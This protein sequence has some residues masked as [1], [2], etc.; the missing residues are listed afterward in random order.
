M[1]CLI[2]FQLWFLADR[3]NGQGRR[4]GGQGGKLPRAPRQRRGPA[5]LQNEFLSSL[6]TKAK[7]I[8]QIFIFINLRQRFVDGR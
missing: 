7:V 1:R 6:V 2:G 8:I 3:T 4:G 5:I